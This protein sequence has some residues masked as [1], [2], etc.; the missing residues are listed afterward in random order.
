MESFTLIDGERPVPVRARVRAGRVLL[1][2]DALREALGWELH[3]GLLCNDAMC[4]RIGDEATLLHDGGVDLEAFARALDRPLAVD[5]DERAACL[6]GS[7]RERG[8]AL[9]SQLA[10]DFQLPDLAGRTHTLSGQRGKKVL[11]VT[12]ASW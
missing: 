3:E 2:A 1:D 5:A 4:I 6:G 8:E 7:A 10:P 11:L 12:W 9:A